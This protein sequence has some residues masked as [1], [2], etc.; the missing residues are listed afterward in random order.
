MSLAMSR[1]TRHLGFG[2]TYS[3]TFTQPYFL[4]R[5]LNSLGQVSG[6]RIAFNVITFARRSD[7]ADC[8]YDGLVE[9]GEPY[10][11]V[12]EF[13]DALIASIMSTSN[14]TDLSLSNGS[15]GGG[16]GRAQVSLPLSTKGNDRACD[17][18][19]ESEGAIAA[20]SRPKARSNILVSRKQQ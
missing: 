17:A 16:R 5:H 4:A 15:N 11:P 8:G 7:H 14:P 6:G 2:I 12:E 1:V 18:G 20:R 9:H 10:D 13:I 3:T 19:D